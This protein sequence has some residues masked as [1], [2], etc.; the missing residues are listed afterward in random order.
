MKHRH[1]LSEDE[2][3]ERVLNYESSET[4]E[5]LYRFGTMM[6]TENLDRTKQLD[7][8]AI[9]LAG[10]SAAVLA[11][12]VSRLSSPME[13]ASWQAIPTV[14]AGLSA[15]IGVA[16]SLWALRVRAFHWFSKNQWFENEFHVL[17]NAD[18]LKRAHLL[19]MHRTNQQMG[20]S[21]ER[22]ANCVIASQFALAIAALGLA[23]SLFGGG[24]VYLFGR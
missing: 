12:L 24:L 1:N 11:F 13:P 8:K 4:T 16:S 9:T 5:E 14:C 17:E 7:A 22:K 15:F 18:R 19:A 3:Y 20:L 23:A 10:Y 6:V 21:N 2:V